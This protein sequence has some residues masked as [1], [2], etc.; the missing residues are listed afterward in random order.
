MC[1]QLCSI[2]EMSDSESDYFDVGEK[3]KTMVD[4]DD[5]VEPAH[6]RT[7]K[8]RGKDIEWLGVA[9]YTEFS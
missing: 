2:F 1:G 6:D 5:D 4:D 3:D 9:R 7:G 8:G